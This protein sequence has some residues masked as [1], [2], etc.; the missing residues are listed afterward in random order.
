MRESEQGDRESLEPSVRARLGLDDLEGARVRLRGPRLVLVERRPF[1]DPYV[2]ADC[3]L[4]L[5]VDLQAFALPDVLGWLHA[6]G[7][8]GLL[9]CAHGEHAKWVWFHRGEVVFAASNQRI[10]RL[11]HSLV[12]AGAISFESMREAERRYRAN[13]RFGKTLVECGLLT[14]RELWAGLQRQVEEIVRSLFSYTTGWLCF[15]DGDV[16][17]DNVVRLALPSR[18]LVDEGIR[19]RAELR[20]FVGALAGARV[21]LEAV[22]ERRA[23]LAGAERALFDALAEEAAFVPLCRRLDLDAQTCARMIQLLHRDGAIRIHQIEEDPDRTQRVLRNDAA[24]QLRSQVQDAVK[25]LGELAAAIE[26]V[27]AG[28]RLRERFAGMIEEVAGRFP[29]L[30]SGIRVDRGA[31]L[32]PEQLIERALALPPDRRGDVRD[33]LAALADY[34]E[35]EVK[36]HPSI[37][38][39]EGVL[40]SVEALRATLQAW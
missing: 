36:N 7:R 29:G 13:G 12:R 28:D 6:G 2:P 10:D 19:W 34:L 9:H 17:P 11:G 31:V 30:L 32:D 22:G 38:D 37:A 40:N 27:E 24:E 4:V 3:Q 16:Q 20:R 1:E 14:P 23:S 21:R 25:L 15:W 39:S 33:A 5:S 35:F 26:A 8:S 18:K